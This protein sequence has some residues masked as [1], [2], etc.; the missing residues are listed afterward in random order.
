MILPPGKKLYFLSDF[1][2]GS[3]DYESSRKREDLL[4]RFFL[5]KA[6]DAHAFFLVGDLFDFW[7]EYKHVVPKGFIRFFG[8]LAAVADAGIQLHFF[9]GNHDMWVKDYLT[10]EI[11]LAVHMDEHQF[12]Y[13]GKKFYVAHGDGLGP[14]DHRYKM[15]KRVFRNPVSQWLF[16][17]LPPALGL[18]TANYFSEKSRG[19]GEVVEQSFCGIDNEWLILHSREVLK[20]EH[21][22]YFIYGHRH[23]PGIYTIADGTEY[24]NLGDWISYY[25]YAQFDGRQLTLEYYPT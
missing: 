1:H 25:S 22:D 16:G 4:V 6:D 18:G 10:R 13:N 9:A 15:M 24:V 7:F 2:L 14:G 12:E 5:E 21:F 3:P 11:N 17:I 19:K 20:T 23:L 8:A